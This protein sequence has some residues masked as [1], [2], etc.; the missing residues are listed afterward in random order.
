[1]VGMPS[2]RTA[3]PNQRQARQQALAAAQ[4]QLAISHYR[5]IRIDSTGRRF[6]IN[7]ARIWTL[8]DAD[9]QPCGQTA[10]FSDWHWL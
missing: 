7:S 9:G 8:H 6:A 4:Q 2:S 3:E 10:A 5:G 1:M